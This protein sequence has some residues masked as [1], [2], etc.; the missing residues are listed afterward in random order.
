MP[1]PLVADSWSIRALGLAR[2]TSPAHRR[3]AQLEQPHGVVGSA[4]RCGGAAG[5][6]H[7]CV[8]RSP[9]GGG[10][11]LRLAHGGPPVAWAGSDRSTSTSTSTASRTLSAPMN[12]RYGLMPY[13]DCT[14]DVVA[15]YRSCPVRL[16]SNRNGPAAPASVSVPLIAPPP[17]APGS[18]FSAAKPASGCR[19]APRVLRPVAAISRR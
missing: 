3:R 7:V 5:F 18:N 1:A 10:A 8:F 15:W 12:P 13:R 4:V 6:G 9:A 11:P 2:L 17:S 19:S 14:T 16:T